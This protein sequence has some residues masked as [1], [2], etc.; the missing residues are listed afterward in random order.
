MVRHLEKN[1]QAFFAALAAW[2]EA[3]C[4]FTGR[5][6]LPRSKAKTKGRVLLI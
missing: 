1:W 6:K 2:K 4:R 3:P 5:P